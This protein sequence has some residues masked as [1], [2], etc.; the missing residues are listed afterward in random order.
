[1]RPAAALALLAVL[2]PVL[3]AADD[4]GPAGPLEWRERSLLAQGRLTLPPVSPETLPPGEMV[5]GMDF[6]WGNDLGW[7]QD[8]PGESAEGRR[9]LLDGEHRTLTFDV[10]R[11]VARGLDVGLRVALEW[12]GG[13][14][15]DGVIEWFHGFTSTL[16]LPDNGRTSFARDLLRAD[17]RR[18]GEPL[19]WD[20]RSG[21]HLGRVELFGRWAPFG[22]PGAPVAV[23]ARVALPT[24]TGP[25]AGGDTAVAVQLVG[26][27]RTGRSADIYGGLGAT[28]GSESQGGDLRYAAIRPEAFLAFERRFGRRWSALAESNAAGRLVTNVDRYPAIQ[29][30]LSLGFRFR[31]DR[32]WAFE[33]G[34]TENI[35]DQQATTDFGVQMGIRRR[36]GARR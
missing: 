2:A 36:L 34:F 5:L 7:E 12:R 3:V 10:R 32:G 27:H 35:M 21:T 31:L 4:G 8:H 6:D 25:F 29:W 13:G 18:G 19:Q 1:V 30:Y 9:F 28:F 11:G 33:G 16:G 24:G 15:L 23:V 14:L 20:D 22:R 26:A 17:L